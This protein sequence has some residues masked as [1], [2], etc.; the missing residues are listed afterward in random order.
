MF[1]LWCVTLLWAFSFSLIGVYL[2]GQV[3]GYFA[4][5]S[6]MAMASLLFLPLML[7]KKQF[8][9][10]QLKLMCVGALQLGLMYLFFYHSFLY[11]SVAEVLLFTI[12]TPVYVVLFDSVFG[13]KTLRMAN[14]LPALFAVLGAAVIRITPISG[15]YWFGLLLVQLANLC[16][17][18]GQVAYKYWAASGFKQQASDFGYF[19]IGALLV[20]AIAFMLFGNANKLPSNA[21]Q[22]WVLIWLGFG[23]SGLG[24]LGWNI[25]TKQV[26]AASLAV[27]NNMLIP[28]GLLVNIFFWQQGAI[29]LQLLIGSILLALAI[30]MAQ[31]WIRIKGA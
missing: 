17:A 1:I 14:L 4:V 3:D 30:L 28:A 20:A 26:N 7:T 2:A 8:G 21:T 25:A 31:R 16:F 15:D 19:F 24:Y 11:L 23:A 13:K 27:M 29:Q 5:L 9:Q 12:L 6:R 18:F 22:W 10:R